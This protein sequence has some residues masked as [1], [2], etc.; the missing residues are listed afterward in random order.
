MEADPGKRVCIIGAGIAGLVTA[1]VLREDGFDTVVFEKQAEVGGVWAASRTYPGLRANNSRETYAFSDLPYPDT[2]DEFPTAEQV[3]DYLN[4]YIDHFGLRSLICLSTEVVSV[5]RVATHRFEVLVRPSGASEIAETLEFD[6]VVVCNGVFSEPHVPHIAGQELFQGAILH[7]SQLID[8][9]LVM[10]RR[11]VVVGAGKSALDCAA[12]A[13][14]HAQA[15][16]L[17]FRS[18]HWTVQH[19]I[20]GR[21]RADWVVLTRVFELFLPYHRQGRF[22]AF[23]HGPARSLI[24]LWWQVLCSIIR[25]M[26]K[27]PAVL[28]PEAA[29]PLG[30]ESIVFGEEF[31]TALNH[32]QLELRRGSISRFVGAEAIELDTTEKVEADVVILAT[33]WRQGVPFLDAELLSQVQRNRRLYLYRQILPPSEPRLGFNGYASSKACPLTSE[34]AA[35]WLSQLFTGGLEIPSVVEMEREI[36]RVLDWADEVFPARNQGYYVGPHV[37]PYLDELLRDMGLPRWRAGNWLS[38]YFAPL[39]PGRYQNL[40]E[41]RRKRHSKGPAGASSW[42]AADGVAPPSLAPDVSP[43]F[44]REVSD[45]MRKI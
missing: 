4:A 16:T 9:G 5:S 13:G 45:L 33:G 30:I 18:P 24:R 27:I 14:R 40:G 38:E 42:L 17:V 25:R 21:I 11:V 34:V 35:H 6:F 8:P 39:W 3:R 20:I 12:W 2:A 10:G 31:Y 22:Q 37:A 7:S 1:K 44:L 28:V 26:R 15:C 23:L 43:H 36:A 29:L 41:Q 32:G 19:Y